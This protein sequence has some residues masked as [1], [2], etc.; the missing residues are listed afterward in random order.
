MYPV[1]LDVTRL[2]VAIAGN[3][4]SAARRLAGLDASG[5]TRV[6]VFADA[7]GAALV[8]AAGDRLV[9][10]LPEAADLAPVRLLLIA[11]LGDDAASTLAATARAMGIL[12]N[13]EDRKRWCEFHVP[14]VIRRGDLVLTVS[15]NGRSPGLARRIRRF[16]EEQFGP[17]WGDRTEEVAADRAASRAAGADMTTVSRRTDA[18]IERRGWLRVARGRA[19]DR[20]LG[21]Q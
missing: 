21:V 16:I 7:P 2:A 9:R 3:G 4:A 18:L 17:E 14:A 15:T 1:T 19:T 11:G 13:V 10:R 20:A 6:T 12:V 8:E 5:A